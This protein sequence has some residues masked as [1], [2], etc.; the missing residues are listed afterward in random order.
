MEAWWSARAPSKELKLP[1]VCCR[2]N[3]A[4]TGTPR[5]CL[6]QNSLNLQRRLPNAGGLMMPVVH[7][8]AGAHA[9]TAHSKGQPRHMPTHLA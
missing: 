3:A 9:N 6:L 5:Q 8:L 4:C 1:P 7:L 2:G